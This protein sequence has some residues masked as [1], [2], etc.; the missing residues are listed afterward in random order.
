MRDKRTGT[1]TYLTSFDGE[2]YLYW[3]TIHMMLA[4]IHAPNIT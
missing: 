1:G 4:T 3:I 2:V